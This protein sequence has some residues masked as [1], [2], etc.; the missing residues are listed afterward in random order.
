MPPCTTVKSRASPPS[1]SV[2]RTVPVRGLVESF[3]R[4]ENPIV[5]SP[6]PCRVRSVIQPSA[7]AA[8][9]ASFADTESVTPCAAAVRFVEAGARASEKAVHCAW[10]VD[11]SA[12]ATVVSETASPPPSGAVRHPSKRAPARDGSGSAPSG[13]PAV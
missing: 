11:V 12:P 5:P 6:L 2:T 1:A 7:E 9:H 4:T 3:A 10:S 8:V 13:R